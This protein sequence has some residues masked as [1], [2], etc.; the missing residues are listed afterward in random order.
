MTRPRILVAEDDVKTVA[1]VR[2]YLEDAGYE[3]VHAGDG[4]TALARAREKPSPHLIVLDR[5]LPQADGLA[6]CRALREESDVPIILLTALT[7]ENDRLEGLDAGADDYVCKPFS[8]REL[9]ARVRAVLRRFPAGVRDRRPIA[10]GELLVDP[11]RREVRM[12]ERVVAL[13]PREFGLLEVLA[14]TPGRAFTRD[15]LV[16]RA[17]GDG[18]EAL[19]RTVDAHVVNLRRKLEPDPSQPAWILTVFGVGYRLADPR[20]AS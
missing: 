13:T 4:R 17:F 16:E 6:V 12:G 10:I 20:D 7:T 11:A 15:E 1:A 2:L 5:M 9:V 18:Y 8:P 3:V 14:R 19:D